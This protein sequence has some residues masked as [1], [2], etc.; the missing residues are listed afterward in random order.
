MNDKVGLYSTKIDDFVTLLGID[1]ISQVW[2]QV[3]L[4]RNYL[5][6]STTI[7]FALVSRLSNLNFK[8]LRLCQIMMNITPYL[9]VY[10]MHSWRLLHRNRNRR[11]DV[12][13][14]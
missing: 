9:T 2:N 3:R 1:L 6:N 7:V 4:R 11:R 5:Y 13:K 8:A 12:C 14:Q 10:E